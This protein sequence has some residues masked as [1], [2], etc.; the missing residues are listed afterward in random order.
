[1]ATSR[2]GIKSKPLSVYEKLNIINKVDD[3]PNVSCT[4]SA[5]YL[6]ISVRKVLTDCLDGE[7]Q[8]RI[9]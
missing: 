1:M 2:T 7:L 6:G 9:C 4:K 3:D 5:E 8:V